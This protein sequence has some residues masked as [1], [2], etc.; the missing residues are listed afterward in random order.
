MS[1]N[2]PARHRAGLLWRLVFHLATAVAIVMLTALL[3]TIVN[4]AFGLV[5]IENAIDPAE[6]ARDGVPLERMDGAAL[7]AV[8]ADHVSRGL[9]RRFERDQPLAERGRD[10]V[11]NLV[12]ERVVDPSVVQAWSLWDSLFRRRAVVAEAMSRHPGARLV[13]RSWLTGSFIADAQSS[14]PEDAGVRAAIKGSLGTILITIL[15]A[16]PVGVGAAIYLEEYARDNRLNRI[17]QTNINNLSGVPS[18]IYGMLGLTVFVRAMEP[19]TSGALFGLGDGSANGRTILSAGLTLGLLILPVIIINAQE[20]IKAVPDS[21]RQ[22]SYGL[23]ATK[24][25]TIRHHVLPSSLDRILTGTILATSRAI[26]ETAPMVV[27]GASTLVT[28]DPTGPFSKFTT[29]PIQIYQWTA[30]PQAEF[31]N[32]AAAA[33]LVLLVLLLTL[34]A[35]AILLRNYHARK[36]VGA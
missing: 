33:I 29:L 13:F 8:L 27:V 15:F 25:Q 32:A 1:A 34:N 6:L 5:A 26:G 20:A 28:L 19:V 17:I 4:R 12:V 36:Q 24:W 21:L 35:T 23:G 7:T 11:Y 31:R 10:E 22:S 18:I 16:F 2:L 30:R 14:I 3:L 9:L